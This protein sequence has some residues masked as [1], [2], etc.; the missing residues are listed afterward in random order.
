MN[1]QGRVSRSLTVRAIY[2]L[3]LPGLAGVLAI[4]GQNPNPAEVTSHDTEPTFKLEVQRNLVLVRV[5]VR[6]AQGNPVANLRKEDFRLLDNGKPQTVINF[7]IETPPS[8][9]VAGAKP[10]APESQAPTTG[11]DDAVPFTP[12]RFLAICFDD[13]HDNFE[14]LVRTRD[15]AD[16]YLASR[17]RP[18]DRVGIFTSSGQSAQDFTDDLSKVHHALF[19]L[20]SRPIVPR[21]ADPCPDIFPY[22]AFLIVERRDKPSLESAT[23]EALIC[24]YHSDRRYY[25]DA[26]R[27]AETEAVRVLTRDESQ[28]AYSFRELEQVVRRMALLPGQRDVVFLSP[29]FFTETQKYA[30]SQITDRALRSKVVVNTFDSKG[31]FAPIPLGDASQR[32]VVTPDRPDLVGQKTQN[33]LNAFQFD[34]DVLSQLAEDTGGVFFHNSNDY[35]QGFRKVGTLV[36]TYYVLGFSPRNLKLDGHFHNL[37]VSLNLA[38]RYSLQARRGYFAPRQSEDAATQEREDLEEAIFS[39]DELSGLPVEL[40][41]QFFKINERDT[42]LSILAHL[43]LHLLHFRKDQGRNMN[44]LTFVTALF[45]RDGKYV[46]GQ[47]KRLELRLFDA[48]LEKLSKSGIAIK[49]I[50]DIPPGT[51]LVREVVRDAEGGQLSGL[52][53]TVEIPF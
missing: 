11:P 31:L 36:G 13:V 4:A 16:R 24:R 44:N 49:T 22:Q 20:R 27:D 42:K 28:S 43:D 46:K 25:P 14:D 34:V 21:D 39:Q 1:A 37:K 52:N 48:S 9:P 5:V 45:D 51:Y 7:A 53:R 2:L 3:A 41:T 26:Q 32:P 15:A 10:Q 17:A 33:Q 47:E 50:F 18:G 38:G 6:D 35:D 30:I 23:E 40:H 12:L 19:G 29:G 8:T